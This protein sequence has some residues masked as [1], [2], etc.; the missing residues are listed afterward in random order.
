MTDTSKDAGFP[1]AKNFMVGM[2][3]LATDSSFG[4]KLSSGI[5][6]GKTFVL[7]S[8]KLATGLAGGNASS[9]ALS[10]LERIFF[11]LGQTAKFNYHPILSE[12]LIATQ[13]EYF[14][15]L[16]PAL[17]ELKFTTTARNDAHELV[18]SAA[19]A[20]HYT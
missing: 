16:H 14:R 8:E 4:T 2:H 20:R 13:Q 12:R 11:S 1:E 9:F 17:T 18:E 15:E 19:K 3:K 6:Q 5:T 10:Q 7:D